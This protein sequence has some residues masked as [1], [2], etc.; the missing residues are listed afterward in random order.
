MLIETV[1]L[2]LALLAGSMLGTFYF[3][4]LWW[5]VRQLSTSQYVALL[6]MFSLLLRSS[7]VIV[8]FYFILGD[9]WLRLV[10]GLVGFILVRLI[11]TR[12][13]NRIEQNAQFEKKEATYESS[14]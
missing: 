5:T 7:V 14:L 9:N 4:G 2:V 6:F 12:L 8:G 11:A 10:V 1:E 13:I 3:A